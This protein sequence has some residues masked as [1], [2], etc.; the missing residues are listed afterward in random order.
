MSPILHSQ[1]TIRQAARAIGATE[2]QLR[3]W[4]DRGQVTLEGEND[5]EEGEWRRMSI[6]D[7]LRLAVVAKIASYGV[8]VP[9]ANMVCADTIDG[10]LALLRRYRNPPAQAIVTGLATT[11]LGIYRTETGALGVI[12]EER[13]P[14][15]LPE[16][17]L[18]KGD[19]AVFRPS[20]IAS[21]ALD[22]MWGAD[23]DDD[24]GDRNAVTKKAKG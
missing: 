18:K 7:V 8:S 17:I 23:L 3:N 9:D 6:Y 2:K 15:E 1:I 16:S 10:R 13:K 21:R 22:R 5:R 11:V 19:V 24:E 14:G 20:I 12:H 4:L